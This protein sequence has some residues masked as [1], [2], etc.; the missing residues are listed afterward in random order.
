[1][2]LFQNKLFGEKIT[3]ILLPRIVQDVISFIFTTKAD[4]KAQKVKTWSKVLQL[5]SADP[6]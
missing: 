3:A 5:T 4:P 2:K 1:M 6:P